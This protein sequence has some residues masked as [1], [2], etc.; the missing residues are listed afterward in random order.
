MKG[1]GTILYASGV[2]EE[3]GRVIT[4]GGVGV[5]FRSRNTLREHLVSPKD[6]FKKEECCHTVYEHSCK[7]CAALY[8]GETKHPPRGQK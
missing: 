3:L 6:K 8:I 7:T 5:H 2:S 4:K 1:S